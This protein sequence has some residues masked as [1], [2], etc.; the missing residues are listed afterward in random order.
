[1]EIR[2]VRSEVD[3]LRDIENVFF[4]FACYNYFAFW[5]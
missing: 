2:K 1:M 5:V 3:E 4:N